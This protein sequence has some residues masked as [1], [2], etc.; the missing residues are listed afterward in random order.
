MGR[1]P[2]PETTQTVTVSQKPS[3]GTRAAPTLDDLALPSRFTPTKILG[4]G[5]MGYVVEARDGTLNR[6]VA[7]K[8]ISS[9]RL[10]DATSRDRFLREARAV[11]ALRHANIVTVFDLD[12]QGKFLVMELVSGETLKQRLERMGALPVAEVRRIGASLLSALGAAHDAGIIHRD[13]K[14][15]NILLGS[16]DS[17][18]LA[19]FGVA[20]TS[21]SELTGTGEVIGTPAYMA[22]EQLR[23]LDTDL[24]CDIYSAGVTLFEAATGTR[25]HRNPERAEDVQQKI[26][27]SIL[28]AGIAA[29]ISRAVSERPSD[30]FESAREFSTALTTIPKVP[31]FPRWARIAAGIVAIAATVAL[32]AIWR[33]RPAAQP[34]AAAEGAELGGAT[35]IELGVRALERQD[36]AA[37]ERHLLAADQSLAEVHYY[38]GILYWWTARASIPELDK[39]IAGGLDERATAVAKAIRSLVKLEY[40]GVVVEFEAL[41]RRYPKDREVLYGLFEALF[42]GGRPADAIAVYKQLREVAPGFSLGHHH[43]L[44]YSLPRGDIKTARW[45]NQVAIGTDRVLWEARIDFAENKP[46]VAIKQ[47]DPVTTDRPQISEELAVAYAL[48]GDLNKVRE[49]ASTLEMRRGANILL[50]VSA[51]RQTSRGASTVGYLWN[52]AANSAVVPPSINASNRESLLD[53]TAF[54]AVENHP[55]PPWPETTRQRAAKVLEG[56]PRAYEKTWIEVAVGRTLL[57]G[58]IRDQSALQTFVDTNPFP[59]VREVAMAALAE[60]SGDMRGA[61]DAWRRSIEADGFG[62]FRIAKSL[63]LARALHAVRDQAAIAACEAVIRPRLFHWSWGA[64]VG[65]CLHI[66]AEAHRAAGRIKDSQ[67]ASRKLLELRSEAAEGDPLVTAARA[68][69]AR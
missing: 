64:A 11:A 65:E 25:L 4:A 13:V 69:L 60:L 1:P 61:A 35:S 27:E 54:L 3:G 8:V 40:P 62:R 29:A 5:A 32:L 39:A 46:D 15:A 50:A 56:L 53:F 20:T 47:L 49:I 36:F 6:D 68:N 58:I 66:T 23:G 16:D 57:A 63:H 7:V 21:D 45:A 18:K 26:V 30:R 38:L 24:R 14:P 51:A 2:R 41:D 48:A 44:T 42:H 37:A 10:H 22:P 55:Q 17:V 9:K 19:D 67:D 33:T 34:A 52:V 28:D 59:E 31:M 43:V 12:P